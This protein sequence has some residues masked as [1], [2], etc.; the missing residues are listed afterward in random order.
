MNVAHVVFA[1]DKQL[2]ASHGD[3]HVAEPLGWWRTWVRL[4]VERGVDLHDEDERTWAR[5][6]GRGSRGSNEAAGVGKRRRGDL[7]REVIP[8][9]LAE[10]RIDSAPRLAAGG[11]RGERRRSRG[12]QERWCTPTHCD[13]A[14]AA[15]VVLDRF[16]PGRATHGHVFGSPF[17]ASTRRRRIVVLDSS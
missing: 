1:P 6:D 8:A 14:D 13:A 16:M 17:C 15:V 9:H 7:A 2:G 3:A 5:R 12:D 4:D 10:A 11:A